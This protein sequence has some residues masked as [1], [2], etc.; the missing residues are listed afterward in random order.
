MPPPLL[1]VPDTASLDGRLRART[2][3]ASL[4]GADPGP[5]VLRCLACAHRCRLREGQAGACGVR[6]VA[7]GVLRAPSGYVAR[8]YVRPVETNT[9]YHVL[10]GSLALTFGMFGCDLK[11]G[12]CH[13]FTVSQALRDGDVR[14][15]IETRRDGPHDIRADEIADAAL[16]TGCRVVAAAYNEPM[17]AAEWVREVFAACRERGLITVI[18]SDGHTTP[19]ALEHVRAVTDVFRVDLKA[20]D[21]RGYKVLGGR[22]A[23]VLAA[24]RAARDLGLWVEVVT[25]VVPGLNDDEAGVRAAAD[26]LVA[27]DPG[28]PWHLNAFQPRYRMRDRAATSP[29]LLTSMAGIA[30][31]RGL[32]FV[33]VGNVHRFMPE[34]EHTR[35]PVCHVVVVERSDYRGRAVHLRDGACPG[36]GETVEG[37]WARLA[38][39]APASAASIAASTR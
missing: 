35:C 3:E 26:A 28:I 23:P 7:G 22:H 17:I 20:F 27:I 33:Y 16:A 24:V 32:R 19:E 13:N 30:Y 12:Y 8:A 39:H 31:A 29:A 1:L 11:C 36:C 25:L 2:V 15:A 10:P 5:G 34:L 21:E 9:V 6:F 37:R 14:R 4:V 18:V 38:S